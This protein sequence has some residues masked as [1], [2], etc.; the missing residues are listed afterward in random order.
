MDKR[1]VVG[2]RTLKARSAT[3]RTGLAG[4]E[5]ALA[6]ILLVV[7]G[8]AVYLALAGAHPRLPHTPGSPDRFGFKCRQCGQEWTVSR[9]EFFGRNLAPPMSEPTAACPA[10]KAR[11]AVVMMRCPA[12]EKF[13]LPEDQRPALVCPHC[14][15][16]L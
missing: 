10:C 16:G 15:A 14:K 4:R 11:K 3:F 2:R 9:E 6:G 12:C 13:F 1:S 5:C 8:L 7:I